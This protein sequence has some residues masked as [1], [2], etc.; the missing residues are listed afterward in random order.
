MNQI[1]ILVYNI[2]ADFYRASGSKKF[3]TNFTYFFLV[4][5]LKFLMLFRITKFLKNHTILKYSL[6]PF[7]RILFQHY[8]YKY[9]IDIPLS[10]NIG[11]GLNIGHF[12]GITITGKASIGK[13]CKI[14][15]NILIGETNRGG[16]IGAPKI[17]NGV[18]IGAGAKIIGGINIGNNV[19]IGAN[20]VVTKD[21][22]HNAV[23]VGIPAKIISYNGSKE[24]IM[25]T[26]Y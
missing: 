16:H 12:G 11:P 24:F 23:V 9:G 26:D 8:T 13:N 2:Y 20:A 15:P 1:K 7:F 3:F 14:L 18:H 22:P 17:G 19:A 6:Y 25:N 10:T 5:T 4:P 21:V